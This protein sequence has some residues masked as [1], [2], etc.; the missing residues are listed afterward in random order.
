MSWKQ[1]IIAIVAATLLGAAAYAQQF[2]ITGT[3]TC[4]Y[5]L[6]FSNSCNSGYLL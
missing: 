1:I 6:D 4:S 3:A 5:S 2:V